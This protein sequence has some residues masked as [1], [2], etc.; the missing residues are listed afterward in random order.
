MDNKIAFLIVGYNTPLFIEQQAKC[1]KRFCKDDKYDILLVDNSNTEA[2]RIK[3]QEQCDNIGVKY[4]KV[5]SDIVKPKSLDTS[6]DH[7]FALRYSFNKF[8]DEYDY[9][10]FLDHD[11]FPIK[12]FSITEFL[13]LNTDNKLLAAG[14]LQGRDKNFF[15]AGCFLLN[16]RDVDLRLIGDFSPNYSLGLD[17]NGDT[18]KLLGFYGSDKFCFFTEEFITNNRFL[19]IIQEKNNEMRRTTG[20]EVNDPYKEYQLIAGGGAVF[21]HFR[22]SSNYVNCIL[23]GERMGTLFSI[24]EDKL[25]NGN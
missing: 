17:T 7:A 20:S 4:F 19:D 22:G 10:F 13:K 25:N 21:L 2:F 5:E 23:F 9:I 14:L 18:H 16:M 6:G 15:W 11:V 12:Q 3:L 1:I 8:K 24:L